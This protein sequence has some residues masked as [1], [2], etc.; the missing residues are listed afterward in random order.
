MGVSKLIDALGDAVVVKTVSY[1]AKVFKRKRGNAIEYVWYTTD[2]NGNKLPRGGQVKGT[3][4]YTTLLEA[5]ANIP[6]NYEL[7]TGGGGGGV[8]VS[9]LSYVSQFQTG[10]LSDSGY[11][12]DFPTQVDGSGNIWNNLTISVEPNYKLIVNINGAGWTSPSNLLFI[13]ESSSN[14]L[15]KA[16]LEQVDFSNQKGEDI[17]ILAVDANTINN[18]A[19]QCGWTFVHIK[20]DASAPVPTFLARNPN[21]RMPQ[22]PYTFP[23]VTLPANKKNVIY[24]RQTDDSGQN[25]V[26]ANFL[27]KGWGI[28]KGGTG[29]TES[30]AIYDEWIRGQIGNPD[31]NVVGIPAIQDLSAEWLRNSSMQT[32]YNAFTQVIQ[33]GSGKGFLFLDWEYIGFDV[34]SQDVINKITTLFHKFNEANPNCLLTSYIHANPFYD[35]TENPDTPTGRDVHN[36][37]YNKPLGEIAR[38]FFAYTGEI[39]DVNT[40]AGTG[41]Y[42]V[43]GKHLTTFVGIYNYTI[44]KTVLYQTIQEF[45]LASKFNMEALSMNWSLTE[46]LGGS[47]FNT[48]PRRFKKSNGQSYYRQTKPPAPPSHQRN[49][50]ILSNFFG[51][52]AWFWDEPLP[53]MEG[54]E[55][56]GSNARDINDQA[57]L[58]NDFASPHFSSM[59]FSSMVG[60]DY[61]TRGLYEMSFNADIIGTGIDGIIRPEFSTNGG[62]SYYSG[63]DLLPASAQFLHI[64][65]VRMKKHPTLNE[66]VLV[67]VTMYQNHWENQTIKVKI[68]DQTIDVLL[69]GLHCS[70]KRI[71]LV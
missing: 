24:F 34:F 41:V 47:D 69:K 42:E 27:Q 10:L 11:Q 15:T 51:K 59:H 60:I 7:L 2:A 49:M 64:P 3:G 9:G 35:I 32:I 30:V 4:V 23:N 71:R 31:P 13:I 50:T 20:G 67:A 33:A 17:L 29:M 57:Y 53:F 40:G 56:W 26:S 61:A 1:F 6:A 16:Q 45:E 63:N 39:L 55:Y 43:M 38:G 22:A 21:K 70:L 25:E 19:T 36:A 8:V 37:K 58:S 65:I 66:W 46:G 14:Y 48:W 44:K 28:G 18:E 54:Y 52:G 68:G 12:F 62:Q 5:Q